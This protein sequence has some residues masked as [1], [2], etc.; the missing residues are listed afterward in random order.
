MGKVG[1][2]KPASRDVECFNIY[3][4]ITQFLTKD[5]IS[6]KCNDVMRD[7]L[8]GCRNDLIEIRFGSALVQRGD[9]MQDFHLRDWGL[10]YLLYGL[11]CV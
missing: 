11:V 1:E 8:A 3:A 7:L 4:E 5:P 9:D 10:S 2:S 6:V